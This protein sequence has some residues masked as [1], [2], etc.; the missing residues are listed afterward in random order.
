MSG[1]VDTATRRDFLAASAVA[2]PFS[3]RAASDV[4]P[5]HRAG[6]LAG[7]VAVVY[8]AAGA[9]GGAV[10]RAF[11]AEGAQLF[12]AGRTRKKVDALAQELD[13]GG[14]IAHAAQVDALDREA[15]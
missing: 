6:L 8:G 13:R 10:T 12:L 15:I 11:A 3:T 9:I 14:V 2:L 5:A 7:K 4:N 1:V